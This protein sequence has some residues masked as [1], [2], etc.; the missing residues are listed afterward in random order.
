MGVKGGPFRGVRAGAIPSRP[1]L[2]RGRHR[3]AVSTQRDGY[4]GGRLPIYLVAV[5]STAI[6]IELAVDVVIN[7]ELGK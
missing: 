6:T 2:W 4:W 3:M 7:I 1:E 5:G